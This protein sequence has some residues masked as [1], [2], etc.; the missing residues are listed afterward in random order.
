VGVWEKRLPTSASPIDELA[1]GRG[2]DAAW[3]DDSLADLGDI[4]RLLSP[5][6]AAQP[7]VKA[8]AVTVPKRLASTELAAKVVSEPAPTEQIAPASPPPQAAAPVLL[9]QNDAR[10]RYASR[11]QQAKQQ[12]DFRGGDAVVVISASA[13]VIILLVVLLILLLR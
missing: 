5:E 3:A 11:E 7:K 4:D 13:L 2:G 8:K 12:Q 1:Y 10:D 6:P 9:A